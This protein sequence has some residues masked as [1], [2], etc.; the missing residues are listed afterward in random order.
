MAHA[1]VLPRMGASDRQFAGLST[2]MVELQEASHILQRATK[3]SLVIMDELGRGTSTHDG[4]A[5]AHA[6]LQHL[7]QEV[8]RPALFATS[9]HI[10]MPRFGPAHSASRWSGARVPEGS[11][12]LG[13]VCLGASVSNAARARAGPVHD[14]LRDTL[15][16]PGQPGGRRGCR[17]LPPCLYGGRG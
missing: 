12:L 6:T 10:Y 7:I 11:R 5:I 4:V 3:R 16:L 2:F 13:G 8:G 1:V 14:P 15:P 9:S 17:Q